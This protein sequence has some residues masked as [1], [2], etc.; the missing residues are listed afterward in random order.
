MLSGDMVKEFEYQCIPSVQDLESLLGSLSIPASP[1]SFEL[2][3]SKLSV[4]EFA[5]REE[6]RNK[7]EL[8]RDMKKALKQ[9]RAAAKELK[10]SRLMIGTESATVPTRKPGSGRPK[11][12]DERISN[13]GKFFVAEEKNILE[14]GVFMKQNNDVVTFYEALANTDEFLLSKFEELVAVIV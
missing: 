6:K 7:K 10:N 8:K 14:D 1:S 3:S 11:F 5:A 4:A 12:N 2:K 13:I 9:E